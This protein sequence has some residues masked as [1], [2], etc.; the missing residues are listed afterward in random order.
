MLEKLLEALFSEGEPDWYEIT[1]LAVDSGTDVAW[2]QAL[3]YLWLDQNDPE[4][5]D[6]CISELVD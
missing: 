2:L 4:E 6:S 3:H 5:F 1:E